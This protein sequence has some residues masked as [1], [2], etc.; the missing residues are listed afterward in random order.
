MEH[1]DRAGSYLSDSPAMNGD[2]RLPCVTPNHPLRF[3][4][5]MHGPFPDRSW[6]D[7]V[8]EVEAL[9]YSTMFVPDHFDEGFGPV[10]ALASAAAVTDTLKVGALVFDCDF[11][12]PAVHARELATID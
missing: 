2:A 8:H 5:E 7:S 11:R 3:A 4:I 1:G 12:H 10:A 9:G 6:T